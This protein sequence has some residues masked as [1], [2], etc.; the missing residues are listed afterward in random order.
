[1]FGKLWLNGW[2]FS[3][4]SCGWFD[5]VVYLISFLVGIE[6]IYCNVV[7]KYMREWVLI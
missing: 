1:M 6:V 2:R 3:L 5:N 4:K 7:V